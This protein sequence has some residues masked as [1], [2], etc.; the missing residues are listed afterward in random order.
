MTA[1][2]GIR[3]S[4][5][6][7]VGVVL[8]AAGAS[9][10]MQKPKQLLPFRGRSLVRV[11]GETA[12][13]SGCRPV[14]AVIGH[15]GEKVTWKLAGLPM[16]MAENKKWRDGQSGSVRLGVSVAYNAAPDL[17]AM[18]IMVCD[19]PLLTPEHIRSLIETY[20]KTDKTIV[21]ASYDGVTGVPVLFDR[22]YFAELN[23]LKGDGGAKALLEKY[24]DEVAEVTLPEAAFDVDTPDDLKRA[25]E[26]AEEIEAASG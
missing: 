26:K 4:E 8:L 24:P 1:D 12:V 20:E 3:R 21:A 10:R 19:Q 5:R 14:V 16:I 2:K 18:I 13:E 7:H 9:E 23:A 22:K 17:D 11:A 6:T 15:A 25:E